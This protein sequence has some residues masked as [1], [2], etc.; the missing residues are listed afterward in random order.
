MQVGLTAQGTSTREYR[1]NPKSIT[2][3]QVYTCATVITVKTLYIAA[4]YQYILSLVL[5]QPN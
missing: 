4:V 2:A 5:L 1:L 3:S